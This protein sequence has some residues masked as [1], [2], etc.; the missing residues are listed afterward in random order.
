LMPSAYSTD[1]VATTLAD[2][3]QVRKVAGLRGRRR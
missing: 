2:P 3:V 1:P